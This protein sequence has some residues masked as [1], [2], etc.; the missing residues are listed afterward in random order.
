MTAIKN[1]SYLLNILGVSFLVGSGITYYR[2]CQIN[3][4]L[5]V[6]LLEYSLKTLKEDLATDNQTFNED[7]K[8]HFYIEEISN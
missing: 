6:D 8:L 3:E 4:T 2:V 5:G 1:S 7:N